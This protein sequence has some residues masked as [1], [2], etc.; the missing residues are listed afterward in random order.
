MG[1][2][3]SKP[4]PVDEKTGASNITRS[5]KQEPTAMSVASETRLSFPFYPHLHSLASWCS[6]DIFAAPPP[7]PLLASRERARSLAI[8]RL[9]DWSETLLSDAKV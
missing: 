8:P 6:I 1:T 4:E 3:Y 2:I 7:Y 9:E 5:V